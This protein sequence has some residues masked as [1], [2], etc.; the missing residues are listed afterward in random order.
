M[1]PAV[2]LPFTTAQPPPS[3]TQR[4]SSTEIGQAG[5]IPVP[6]GSWPHVYPPQWVR[7]QGRIA[8][9]ESWKA[10]PAL[11]RNEELTKVMLL[12]SLHGKSG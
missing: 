2:A 7:F 10:P 11:L 12:R 4:S 5:P 6:G 9:S 8:E 3:R 1:Q